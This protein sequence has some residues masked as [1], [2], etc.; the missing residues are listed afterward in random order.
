MQHPEVAITRHSTSAFLFLS[1]RQRKLLPNG[2]I[3][4]DFK[5]EILSFDNSHREKMT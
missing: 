1:D 2:D 4:C 5:K 3:F